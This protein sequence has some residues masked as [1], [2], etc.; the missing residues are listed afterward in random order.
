[1]TGVAL[2]L[3]AVLLV[4]WLAAAA[5]GPDAFG[6]VQAVSGSWL[7]C[8]VLVGFTW[9]LFYHLCNGIR[10]LFWD[11]GFGFEL[12]TARMSGYLTAL[13]SV[14]LTA[15]AWLAAILGSGGGA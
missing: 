8:L 10:H 14:V 3:G 7:G 15:L 13:A 5:A 11:A 9:A 4:W 1:M 12:S 2:G 6:T